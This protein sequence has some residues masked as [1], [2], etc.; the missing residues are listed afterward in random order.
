MRQ[1]SYPL[2]II[3]T[4]WIILCHKASHASVH[5]CHRFLPA[6]VLAHMDLPEDSQ[7]YRFIVLFQS[8]KK[9]KKR[10]N[11]KAGTN[12]ICA[13]VTDYLLHYF[14]SDLRSDSLTHPVTVQAKYRPILAVAHTLLTF[15]L[16][17]IKTLYFLFHRNFGISTALAALEEQARTAVSQPRPSI[18]SGAWL[19]PTLTTR[20]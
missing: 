15:T 8:K 17:L 9:R 11:E 12:V 7:M 14:K 2:H 16:A 4:D 1:L 5:S 20:L 6:A 10:Q 19:S 13:L 18:L 3:C